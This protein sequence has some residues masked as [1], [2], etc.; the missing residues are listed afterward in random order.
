MIT[1][2]DV[3]KIYLDDQAAL[4]EV[5]FEIPDGDFVYLIGHSGAG[6]S[7][8]LRLLTREIK[9]SSGQIYLDEWDLNELERS[10]VH[11]LRRM[12]GMVFQD[13]KILKAR[14]V[15]ENVAIALEIHGKPEEEI[16]QEIVGLQTSRISDISKQ[17]SVPFMKLVKQMM[18][19][20]TLRWH[21]MRATL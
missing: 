5:S 2:T 1:F 17:I 12:I 20:H 3:S 7:T 10:Q 18:C 15:Y 6:K 11:Q 9:P 4:N 8:I 14:T 21:V 16:E 19:N 13:F